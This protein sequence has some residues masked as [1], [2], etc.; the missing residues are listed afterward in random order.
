MLIAC[1]VVLLNMAIALQDN[2]PK[3]LIVHPA[4]IAGPWECVAQDGIHGFFI[5]VE[6]A[7]PSPTSSIRVYHRQNASEDAE[8]FVPG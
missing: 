3:N 8:S 4:A 5:K 1:L 6:G 7:G 2:Q